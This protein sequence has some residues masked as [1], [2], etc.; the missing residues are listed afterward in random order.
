MNVEPNKYI[1]VIQSIIIVSHVNQ[2]IHN[3][4]NWNTFD[5]DLK[6]EITNY[7]VFL[8]KDNVSI[9]R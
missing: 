5:L 3:L 9:L 8:K 6:Q 4:Y 7:S 2:I 1:I